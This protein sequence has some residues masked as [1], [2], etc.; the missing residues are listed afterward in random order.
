MD[1]LKIKLELN[2]HKYE[3]DLDRATDLS[4]PNRF[5]GISPSFYGSQHPIAKP[6]ESENFIGDIE[7]GGS[8]NV[9][10]VTVDIHCS[11]THTECSGHI[12]NSGLKIVDVCP[13]NFLFSQLITVSPVSS[14]NTN[15]TYH[16]SLSNELIIP[17]EAIETEFIVGSQDT[18]AIRTSPNHKDK[19]NFNYDSDTPPFFS[20]Q[21]IEFILDMGIKHL[22]VDL[23]S[24]DRGDDDGLL[25][26]H[27]R[28]FSKGSTISELLYIPNKLDDGFGFLQIQIPNWHLDAAPSR[29][30]FFPI[31]F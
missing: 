28:F 13:K 3:I 24:I 30:I 25:G 29:P 5:D 15:D 22:L 6:L 4:I 9:P 14:S 8:C 26:N 12:N 7:K 21:A 18:L 27:H 17:V 1:D 2:N 10:I 23:P 16:K 31:E 11:G 20:N 19:M